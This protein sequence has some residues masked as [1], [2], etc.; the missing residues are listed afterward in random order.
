[1]ENDRKLYFT[2]RKLFVWETLLNYLI[3]VSHKKENS[4]PNPTETTRIYQWN[5]L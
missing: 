3:A 5:E 1:M 4:S 2:A